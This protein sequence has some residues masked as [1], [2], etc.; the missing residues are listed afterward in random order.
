MQLFLK[1]AFL[2][3]AFGAALVGGLSL[4]VLAARR[5]AATDT[6]EVA[7][8]VELLSNGGFDA[9]QRQILGAKKEVL[10]CARFLSSAKLVDALIDAQSR[11]VSVHVL[12]DSRIH[13]PGKG[14]AL[15]RLRAGGIKHI[16]A[17]AKP[18]HA[19]FIVI[20]ERMVITSSAPW[21]AEAAGDEI[22]AP[23]IAM[24]NWGAGMDARS[25]FLGLWQE[26]KPWK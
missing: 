15:D 5:L 23:A 10:V 17:A 12:L 11:G 19:Q 25:F 6:A 20:D 14:Q 2:S 18:L 24:L 7:F 3:L 4:G 13:Q 8:G 9:L 1:R 22:Y 26:A 21:S 16:R